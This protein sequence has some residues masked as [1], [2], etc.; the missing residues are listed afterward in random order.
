VVQFLE[1]TLGHLDAIRVGLFRADS[2]CYHNTF[3]STLETKGIAYIIAAKLTQALQRTIYQS[4]GWWAL[5]A[6]LEL[7]ELPYQ[8]Q[9]WSAPRRIVEVRQS[10]K[11]RRAPGKQLS[12]FADDPASRAGATGPS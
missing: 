9:G 10:I 5:E 4:G 3:L 2:G 7:T 1:S 11:R 8:A 6:G 12:L